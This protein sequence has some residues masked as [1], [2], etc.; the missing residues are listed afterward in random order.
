MENLGDVLR[1]RREELNVSLRQVQESTGI[2][3]AYLSQLEN[4]RIS[5]PSPSV[6]NKLANLYKISYDRLMT[7]AGHPSTSV[8]RDAIFFRTSEGLAEL[9]RDEEK[10]LL[11]YLSFLRIRRGRK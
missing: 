1:R 7:L 5:R 4:H 8:H 2:S 6:L 11:E 3:N 9:S 10:E